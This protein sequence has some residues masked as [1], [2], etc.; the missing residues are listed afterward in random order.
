MRCNICGRLSPGLRADHEFYCQIAKSGS[1]PVPV[2]VQAQA[3]VKAP[4]ES[5]PVRP[6][7]L[8]AA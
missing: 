5:V 2:L 8:A 1:V 4:I 3:Q 7:E 6:R